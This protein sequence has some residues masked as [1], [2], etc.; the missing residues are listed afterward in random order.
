MYGRLLLLA[1]MLISAPAYAQ[2]AIKIGF[3]NTLSGVFADAGKQLE[4]GALTYM[5]EHGDTVAGKKI[6]IIRRDV[7]GINPAV[8]KRLAQELITRDN[9][10]LLAGFLLTP[11][12][13]AAADVSAESHKFM[14]VMNAGTSIIT[15][16]SPYIVRTSVTTPQATEPFA[17]WAFKHGIKTAFTMVP[18]YAPG[19]D[20][21]TSFVQPFEAAG[22]KILG[23]VRYPPASVEFSTYVKRAK[24]SNAEA[25]F[26]FVP[27]G[28]QPAALAKTFAEQGIDPHKTTLLGSGE[29]TSES[30]LKS[31]GDVGL[32]II[33]AWNY[34]YHQAG[35]LNRKFV[36]LYN[37]MHHRNPDTFSIGGYDGMH[38]IYE[39]LKKTNGKTDGKALIEAAKGMQWESP[40]GPMSID[41]RTRDV[42]QTIY[43][44]EVKKAD[45]KIVNVTIDKV[46]NVKDPIKERMK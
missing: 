12:T 20:S 6:E 42:V 2:D 26:Y 25:I 10:D 18:D 24:D 16:K 7:G 32:G 15:T 23:S 1:A 21:E 33:S 8:A 46:E 3:I 43:I 28:A 34:D 14:V 22:G 19:K 39:A 44:R 4:N 5:K 38:V 35:E 11:N 29:A 31:I 45:G 36:K 27:G 13:F 30:A 37:E 40:R 41:P 17:A 9:V